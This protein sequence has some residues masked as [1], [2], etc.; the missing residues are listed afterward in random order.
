MSTDTGLPSIKRGDLVLYSV[1]AVIFLA[2]CAASWFLLSGAR[3]RSDLVLEAVLDGRV[4]ESV[5]IESLKRE[6]TIAIKAGGG[7]NILS[8]GP[9]GIKMISADCRG[10]D[11]L[12]MPM[13]GSRGGIIACLPHR[14][15]V[16]VRS[17]GQANA[18]NVNAIDSMTY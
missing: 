12:R 16:R 3:D 14:L 4:V 2:S 5:D 9:G 6:S 18:A 1:L 11:C 13:I 7:I 10:G 8:V 15:I 17:R